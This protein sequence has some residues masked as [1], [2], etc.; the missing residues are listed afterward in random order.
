MGMT[1]INTD[2]IDAKELIGCDS[3]DDVRKYIVIMGDLYT[4]SY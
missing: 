2:R 1:E 4:R 3:L